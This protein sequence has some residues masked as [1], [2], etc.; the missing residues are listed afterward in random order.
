M[1]EL[2]M[3]TRAVSNSEPVLVIA[4]IGVNHDGDVYKA[5]ELVRTAARCGA[6][7]VKLQIFTPEK[8]AHASAPLVS[9]Q[10]RGSES[11]GQRE[12]LESLC[13]DADGLFRVVNAIREEGLTPLATPFSPED[14][15]TVAELKLPAVKIA[16]PDLVNRVLLERCLALGKPLIVSTGAA[17][18]TE[19]DEAVAFLRGRMRPLALLHC[20]SSYPASLHDAHLRWIGEL[21]GR[22]GL[23][24]GY[25][26]HTTAVSTGGYAVLAGARVIEKHI[27]L[28]RKAPGPDHAASADP[29]EFAEYVH[30]IR[31]A[32]RLYGRTGRRV[33]DCEREV[34]QAARQSL[35]LK[36]DLRA[37][38]ALT[39]DAVTVQ[40]PGVGISPVDMAQ[41]LGRAMK[42][43]AAAG[44]LLQWDMLAEAA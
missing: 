24:T 1:N 7:A 20:V 19:I 11:A 10:Q 18:L 15:D 16:S 8:L 39:A 40:R 31:Q 26:D 30:M 14:V 3:G 38:E 44:T 22:Y 37:G 35:V 41:A 21:A 17:T 25:S 12:M 28:D 6:D 2:M 43:P 23:I 32:E 34:R 33:L 27:T 4:E 36:R 5:L 9:Y 13:L 29:E 42:Q